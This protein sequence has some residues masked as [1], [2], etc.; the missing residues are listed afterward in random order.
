MKVLVQHTRLTPTDWVEIDSTAWGSLPFKDVPPPGFP[1]DDSV[2]DEV[3]GWI[4]N[5]SVQG[6]EFGGGDHYAVEEIGAGGIKITKWNDDPDDFPD[7]HKF[8]EVWTILPLGPDVGL[9]NAISTKQTI[10]IFAPPDKLAELQALGPPQ[11]T[12]LLPTA[13]SAGPSWNLD[14][15]CSLGSTYCRCAESRVARVDRGPRPK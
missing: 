9:G 12:L 10:V 7:G 6:V 11:N 4:F 2:I 15:G 13:Q 14:Y 1:R 3:D 5:V 8:A